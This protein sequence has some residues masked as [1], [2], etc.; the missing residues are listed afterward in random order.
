MERALLMAERS[1]PQRRDWQRP[2]GAHGV[3][4]RG[5]GN[6]PGDPLPLL[7]PPAD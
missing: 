6:P 4:A 2:P 7:A 1:P 5:N 3:V